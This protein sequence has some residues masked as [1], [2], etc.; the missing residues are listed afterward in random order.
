ML[1][2][3]AQPLDHDEKHWLNWFLARMTPTS[4]EIG[5]HQKRALQIPSNTAK[6]GELDE[7]PA[8]YTTTGEEMVK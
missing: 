4:S 1:V 5:V 7:V 8:G 2:Q 6:K 3:H